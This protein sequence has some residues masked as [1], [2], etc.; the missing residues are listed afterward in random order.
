M[1][2][3][4]R[5]SVTVLA[6]VFVGAVATAQSPKLD[7]TALFAPDHLVDVQIEILPADWARLCIEARDLVESIGKQAPKSPYTYFK[8]RLTLDGVSLGEVGIR[9]KGFFGSSDGLRPSLKI[10]FDAYQD[11]RPVAGLDR[12]TLNNN[13]QDP[14]QAIQ[15]LAYRLCRKAGVPA[16]R[17]NH[18][19]VTVNGQSLGI[20]SHIE[21]IRKP[22]L[23]RVFGKSGL[24][25]EGAAAD[26]FVGHLE[27]FQPKGKV[28]G[29][30]ALVPIAEAIAT[31]PIDLVALEKH[32]DLE[33]FLKF[34]AMESLI[35]FW[36]GYAH[37]Q[38]NFYVHQD[39]QTGRFQFIPWGM[40]AGFTTRTPIAPFF[41]RIK[42][43]LHNSI[44]TNRLYR[45]PKVRK[46]YREVFEALLAEVWIE[47]EI[48]A[49]LD[50]IEAL[51]AEHLHPRQSKFPNGIKKLRSWVKARRKI[52]GRELAKWPPRIRTGPRS[53][54][55]AD[56]IGEA[57]GSFKTTWGDGSGAGA[58]ISEAEVVFTIDGKRDEL[59][60]MKV[61]SSISVWPTLGGGPK[62]PA[63]T[64]RG[65]RRSDGKSMVL[66]LVPG[67]EA[68][69]PGHGQ[70]T[71]IQGAL[72]EAEFSLR[73]VAGAQV[74]GGTVT[75]ESAAMTPG[76]EV[77][78]VFAVKIV[79]MKGGETTRY[80]A[81]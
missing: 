48:N 72:T 79:L 60:R 65:R 37:A 75:F 80:E 66:I 71:V 63:I 50:R 51:V 67:R 19:K 35:S 52:L 25:Y 70:P 46:R 49:E 31:D 34:W 74:L 28:K 16:P 41:I 59:E 40:D 22:F 78:G 32:L 27:R 33:A 30:A 23:R 24:L 3:A 6:A 42:T 9:K 26:F 61:S 73:Q 68:F 10:K 5:S 57:T 21:A 1:K 54:I 44:L 55:Y 13:K 47:D 77:S 69:R 14:S 20:Y 17:C 64:I 2:D 81:K 36:D 18:A 11:Q 58:G 7:A 76:A 12:L 62:P 43:V 15:V 8:A 4:R 53:P 45:L 56:L 39:R 29:V 38:N